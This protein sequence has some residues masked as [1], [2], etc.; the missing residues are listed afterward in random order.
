[1]KVWYIAAALPQQLVNCYVYKP[2]SITATIPTNGSVANI[3]KALSLVKGHPSN[4]KAHP[5]NQK[6]SVRATGGTFS[7]RTLER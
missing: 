5:S 1:M 7:V 4:Q 2:Y 3:R 6:A